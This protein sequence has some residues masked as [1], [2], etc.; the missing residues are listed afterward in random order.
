[1]A[2]MWPHYRSQHHRFSSVASALH[3][4][5]TGSSTVSVKVLYATELSCQMSNF[6]RLQC[7]LHLLSTDSTYTEKY[8]GLPNLTDN[9]QGYNEGDLSKHVDQLKD[10]EFL[11]VSWTMIYIWHLVDFY[12][13][14]D[15]SFP[16]STWTHRFMG[17][18][19]ITSIWCRAWCSRKR[20]R[21]KGR[22]L[23]N[24]SIRTRDTTCQ[25]W[26]NTC[27]DRWRSSSMIASK[28]KWVLNVV[29]TL[30]HSM[31]LNWVFNFAFP[32]DRF[33]WSW[34]QVSVTVARV[35]S[36][37]TKLCHLT[38]IDLL[39]TFVEQKRDNCSIWLFGLLEQW[40]RPIDKFH[41][42]CRMDEMK[43]I[44]HDFVCED[45]SRH[46]VKVVHST[47]SYSR[48]SD[49]KHTKT[50]LYR[51]KSSIVTL[52]DFTEACSMHEWNVLILRRIWWSNF[53]LFRECSNICMGIT[54][55][56]G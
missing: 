34:K 20:W 5:R 46:H 19:T 15:I 21:V 41:T 37:R 23:N 14:V 33:Q 42:F 11:L 6:W 31:I 28:S 17:Q 32:R 45:G 56:L 40:R 38:C 26:K 9:Y 35:S 24:K 39:G 55:S 51:K 36:K 25:V 27:T 49:E 47:P 2:D 3:P 8:M 52:K 44:K 16:I 29:H 43:H 13:I 30:C 18:R 48:F 50:K 7:A 54:K 4:S 1:M 22:C 53:F 10:K 12:V